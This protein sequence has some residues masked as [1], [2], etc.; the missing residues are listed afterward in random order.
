MEKLNERL[1]SFFPIIAL[2]FSVLAFCMPEFFVG[3]KKLIIPW[4]GMIMLSMGLTL[5]LDDFMNLFDKK[6]AILLGVLIQFSI[7]PMAAFVI[8]KLFNASDYQLLGMILV[9]ASAGGTASN[10]ICYLAR[11][12]VAMSVTMTSLSTIL[13]VFFMPSLTKVYA[14]AVIE[15]PV[16]KMLIS[17]VKIVLVPVIL[18]MIIRG[19]FEK[20]VSKIKEG[21]PAISILLI[22]LIIA[23]IVALNRDRILTSGITI[24]MMVA[25]HNMTGLL[26]GYFVP[27]FLKYD[28]TTSRTIA[29]EVGM[30]NSGLSVALAIKHFSVAAALPGAI[31]S[32][33][34]NV[35]GSLL[36]AEWSRR[37]KD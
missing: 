9:G 18:G 34:H 31:F 33:W 11:G 4:L 28:S 21:I 1:S 2:G 23:V 27:R 15:V 16:L 20:P 37:K 24:Y 35:T 32:I 5:T 7:M 14:G 19:F 26:F 17:M 25:I 3:G 8:S 22:T 12:N 6:G 13:A 30:Q 10:V 36:A 29:I